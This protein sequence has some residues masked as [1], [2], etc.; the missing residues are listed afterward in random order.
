MRSS[1]L[2]QHNGDDVPAHDM[3][4][5]RCRP[6][7]RSAD[8]WDL[9]IEKDAEEGKLDHL[10]EVALREYYVGKTREL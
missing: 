2:A 3:G 9:Q 8:A 4:R 7:S 1:S 10:A 5:V 6:P